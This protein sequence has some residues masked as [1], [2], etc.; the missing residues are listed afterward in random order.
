MTEPHDPNAP[1]QI[2]RLVEELTRRNQ[3][4]EQRVAERTAELELKNSELARAA[5]FSERAIIQHDS[6]AAAVEQAA[7]GIVMV[8]VDGTIQFVNPAFTSMTGYRSEEVI[9]H[10]PRLLKSGY[11]T[12][13]FYKEL[14]GTIRS[15]RV[16]QGELINRRKG[17]TFYC[18][19][20]RISPVLGANGEIVSYIAVKRDQT[21]R[22][23]AEET[24]AFLAAIVENSE[25]AI[26]AN[27]P[28]GI[29]LTF[30]RGAEVVFGYS[31]KEVIGQH[32]SVLVAPEWLSRIPQY[33]EGVI[34]GTSVSQ[35]ES[36]WL[37][38]DGRKLQVSITGSPIRNADGKVTAI[39]TILHDMTEQKKVERQLREGEELFRESFA[40]APYGMLVCGLDERLIQ[41][42]DAFCRMFG[43]DPAQLLGT[44]WTGM[45]HPDDLDSSLLK[46]E[47]LLNG[48]EYVEA[49]HRCIHRNK[50]VL[51]VRV[52]VSLLRDANGAP[53]HFLGHVEDITDRKRSERDLGRLNRALSTLSR[54][55]E[56]LIH[57]TNESQL[58]EQICDL[59]V[60][61]GG[62]CLAWVGYPENDTDKTVVLKAKAGLGR[63]YLETAQVTWDDSERGCGPTG[64]A[65]KTGKVCV[66]HDIPNDPMFNPWRDYMLRQ[67]FISG[68]SL[69]LKDETRVIG[70]LTIY[71]C[72]PN[73]FDDKEVELLQELAAE[74]AYGISA[75]RSEA[76]RKR[77]EKALLESEDRFRT[78]ADSCPIGIWVTDTQ[79]GIRFANRTYRNF[80]GVT[81][82]Q[83]E[84][85]G[86]QLLLLHPDDATQFSKFF[87]QA[88]RGH[89]PFK[90]EQ[91]SRR[92]D[93]EWRWME[94][95]AE[96][97]FS[98][99]GEFLGF[100]GTSK[101]ITERKLAE[102]VL[103]FQHSLI[104]AIHEVS[105][106]GFLVVN[107]AGDVVSFSKKFLDIW[108]VPEPA[109][110][111][112]FGDGSTGIQDNLFLA[113]NL[114]RVKDPE[115]FLARIRELYANPDAKDHCEVELKDGRVIERYSSSLRGEGKQNL[116]RVWFFRDI[117]ERKRDEQAMRESEERFRV[118]ADCC[119][120]AIW[121]TD[122]E[123]G[124]RFIN[125][126][127]REFSGVTSEQVEQD[128]WQMLLHPDDLPEVLRISRAALKDHTPYN[129]E[130]RRRRADG[131]WRWVESYA[132]PRFSTNG[133]FLGFVGTSKDIA[134]RKQAE[135]DLLS[136]E[137]KF[138]QLAENINEVFWMMPPTADQMLY[139]GPAYEKVWGRTCESLYKNP[140]EWSEAIH[141][142][143]R[144]QA[145]AL[146]AR[147]IQGEQI[148]SEYRIQTPDGQEKWIRD[149]AFPIRDK[150]GHL[151]R[152][153]GI[154][155][156]IT[157]WKHWEEELIS[158]RKCADSASR[159]KSEFLANM[160][161]E[162]RTPMN[163]VLG[164]T[165]LL[166]GT[167]LTSEQRHYAEVV[168]V[169]AKSLLDVINDILD[170]SKI[171]AGKL[172]IDTV[173]F[174]LR[175]LMDDFVS[176]MAGHANQ[177]QLEF[178]CAVAPDVPALLQGDPGRLRQVMANLVGNAMKFTARGEV[179]VRVRLTSENES[180]VGLR[181][182]VRDTGIGIPANKQDILFTS[183]T[184][185][186]A[187]TTRQYGGTGLGLA[188]CRQLVELMGG[189]IGLVSKEGEG[190]EFW[191]TI[192]F[193]KQLTTG[194]V[195]TPPGSVKGARILVV[196]DNA[197]N[198][199][200]LTAQLQSWGA[201]VA[202]AE[203]GTTGLTCLREAV[204]AGEPFRLAVLDMMMPGMDGAVL[205]S[206]ILADE[207][208]KATPLVMMSSMGQRGDAHRL[209]EIGFAAYLG[210]PVRQSDL[211]DCLISVLTGEKP[212]EAGSLITRHSLR[213]ARFSNA[214][215]LLVE[216]NLT[217]QEVA[218][219]MLRRLGWQ[220]DVRSDGKQALT[221][222][223]TLP[224]DLVLMDV[225]M[226]EMDGYEATRRI[227]DPKS[228]VL[229]H[230]IPIIALTAHSMSGDAEKCLAAG[231]S[232]YITK[233]IDP[234]ILAKVVEKWLTRKRHDLAGAPVEAPMDAVEPNAMGPSA[235]GPDATEPPEPM[236]GPM[237]FNREMF[238]RRMM[239]DQDFAREIAVGFL[240]ELPRLLS[241]LKEEAS[242][243]DMESVWKQAHKM[244]GSAANVGA[245][246]LSEVA[247]ELEQTG[248]TG[249]LTVVASLIPELELQ[250]ARLQEALQ[251]W[252]N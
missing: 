12:D 6:L 42:N 141:P 146:F 59:A 22:R 252:V 34:Q 201:I 50:S 166:L 203:D 64:T 206:A 58:L 113:A 221:A 16:W 126:A 23:A 55:N 30:N 191:F 32:I 244:K 233:P 189:E 21:E 104:R 97:R 36:V 231:M 96:P 131:E 186:D 136:S 175:V 110:P 241:T 130:E 70:A 151:V 229:D 5:E 182:S 148:D 215:I 31:A 19:E 178:I 57:A 37:H 94:S 147:Q 15:G 246:A 68:I 145:H 99:G 251:Q 138:R 218:G 199:E 219:G 243:E 236:S 86:W 73:A 234:E 41:V 26:I 160:S 95:Y 85:D 140:M 196:D 216:D 188:I 72:E 77:S 114:E 47:Q 225:Q 108:Q 248:K 78:M 158:A 91:R 51:W 46:M 211:F 208:L 121:V 89:M 29:I 164:M 183:F 174:N 195:D 4:L 197:T 139:V 181:F 45:I 249:D 235:M 250:S 109:I 38:K 71:A 118:M 153:V 119:P 74:L 194:Q 239:G 240:E 162:I 177:K 212:Q 84:L 227:R 75:L 142:D 204:A 44:L 48:S 159:A 93:G 154:A 65:I 224:Y 137:E 100:V 101:D 81:S 180:E 3:E 200:V 230:N 237:I 76:E 103:E 179:V 172:E 17:G 112:N 163:G 20:M 7:D 90:S 39:S 35:L 66:A 176:V 245:E 192:S 56:A 60:Q 87:K 11:Q 122:A 127:Y 168:Q 143:D 8:D 202:A 193:A 184:Q 187:S 161:H 53:V 156:D 220:A 149:G 82:E 105:L 40:H 238:L 217:N 125:R 210:K 242:R 27:T 132:G 226:P 80:S 79:G 190:S 117:S 61:V 102:R 207:V 24:Q 144:E 198:R 155:E 106:D 165:G 247:L 152:V 18:E 25:D 169:S 223:E 185:V 54:C 13:A 157:E 171:E 98:S 135:Q 111:H 128:G 83:L 209:K 123:G 92:A 173:D 14:W 9:G 88:L 120:I 52:R 228:V 222:L 116:G 214:R 129:T 62:Y 124:N 232:D 67:G 49:E 63:S 167:D 134:E 115:A 1:D 150:D 33:I 2:T 133:E 107:G 205:G 10:H 28:A 213:E 43:Y 170:F 69:P